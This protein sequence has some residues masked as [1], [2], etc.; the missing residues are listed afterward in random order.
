MEMIGNA[1][2]QTIGVFFRI[3]ILDNIY[4]GRGYTLG[5]VTYFAGLQQLKYWFLGSVSN[6]IFNLYHTSFRLIYD[7]TNLDKVIFVSPLWRHRLLLAKQRISRIVLWLKMTFTRYIIINNR[8]ILC[9]AVCQIVG[10][11]SLPIFITYFKYALP[12]LFY[13]K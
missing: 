6:V 10:N 5:H 12:C 1:E 3:V 2:F 8:N 7:M 9:Y 4:S 13:L 11:N